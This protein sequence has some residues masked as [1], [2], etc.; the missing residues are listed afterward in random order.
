[1]EN[2]QNQNLSTN[3]PPTPTTAPASQ[4]EVLRS[5]GVSKKRLIL[6]FVAIILILITS[7]IYFLNKNSASKTQELETKT[8]PSPASNAADATANWKTYTQP[9]LHFSIKYPDTIFVPTTID[10]DPNSQQ[11]IEIDKKYTLVTPINRYMNDAYIQKGYGNGTDALPVAVMYLNKKSSINLVNFDAFAGIQF[12]SF[13]IGN[14]DLKSVL[15]QS[16]K[17]IVYQ[18]INN[19]QV[20]VYS[21]LFSGEGGPPTYIK[22]YYFKLSHDLLVISVRLWASELQTDRD[23]IFKSLDEMAKT[24]KFSSLASPIPTCKPRPACLDAT[25][26]CMIP[27]TS[28]MCP[29]TIIP[30]P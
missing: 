19:Q 7:G 4:G 13:Y 2:E 28:D 22:V 1:M 6:G 18:T 12:D 11:N 20:G 16:V 26:R 9:L 24:L 10:E 3:L 27:E 23:L 30:S 29:P 21:E 25:P 8:T 17:G 5:Q 14:K 15:G